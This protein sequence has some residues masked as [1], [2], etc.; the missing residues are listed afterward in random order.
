[1]CN[2]KEEFLKEVGDKDVL[3][4][5]IKKILYSKEESF[6]LKINHTKQQL[7]QF[8]DK[9]NFNYEND[10][11]SQELFGLIWYKDGTWSERH[12]YDGSEW[13]AYQKTPDILIEC[14]S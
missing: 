7:K 11:G 14:K 10:F 9:L 3:C 4:A 1:M 12:E 6:V 2:A 5:I 13:W 8:I